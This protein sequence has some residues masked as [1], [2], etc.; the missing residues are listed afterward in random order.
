MA[1]NKKTALV[2]GCST[3]GIGAAIA[4]ALAKHGHYVFATARDT[5]K[6]PDALKDLPNVTVLQIDVAEPLSVAEA[7]KSV[8]VATKERLGVGALDILVNNAGVGYTMPLLDVDLQHAQR[9]YDINFWGPLRMIQ[10]FSDLLIESRGR[11]VNVSSIGAVVNT[12]W[13]GKYQIFVY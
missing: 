11:V 4:Q 8:T 1:P 5:S 3:G 6:I 13:I 9:V 2:T 7:V 10:A 12:P